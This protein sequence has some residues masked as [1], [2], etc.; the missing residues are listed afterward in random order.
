MPALFLK[1]LEKSCTDSYPMPSD[2]SVTDGI[3]AARRI[4]TRSIK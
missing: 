1:T 4:F 3:A 2:I